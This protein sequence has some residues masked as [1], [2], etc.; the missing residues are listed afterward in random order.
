MAEGIS[1]QK[2]E[3]QST[4]CFEALLNHPHGSRIAEAHVPFPMAAE[5][6]AWNSGN[7]GLIQ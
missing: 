1:F 4:Q 5:D 7:V 2:Q 3:L 6:R